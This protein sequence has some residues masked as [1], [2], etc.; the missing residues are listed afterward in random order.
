TA[1]RW[2]F[3]S[4]DWAAVAERPMLTVRVRTE[5]RGTCGLDD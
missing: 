4:S 2:E 3:R 5:D 1:D